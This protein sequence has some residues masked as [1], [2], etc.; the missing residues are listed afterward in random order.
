MS[1][2]TID[3]IREAQHQVESILSKPRLSLNIIESAF[4]TIS[5][6]YRFPRSKCKRIRKKWAKRKCNYQEIPDTEKVYMTPFGVI[7]HPIL[8]RKL[9][10]QS[11]KPGEWYHEGLRDKSG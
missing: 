5:V 4:L 6:Q 7:C 10:S 1:T 9:R 8:A 3:M 11:G 2:L